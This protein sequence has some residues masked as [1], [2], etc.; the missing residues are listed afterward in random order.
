MATYCT[1][2]DLDEYLSA[3]GVDAFSDHLEL[4]TDPATTVTNCIE[5][6][7][8]EINAVVLK[9]YTLASLVGN[10]ILKDWS[11][12]M[13][14]R[15]LCLRRGNMPPQSLEFEYQEIVDRETGKLRDAE[16]GRI[17]LLPEGSVPSDNLP[18]FSNLTVDRR[19][20]HERVR[21]TRQNSSPFASKA[22]QDTVEQ[23]IADG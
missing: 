22:E 14:C 18:T 3:I 5:R 16:T 1:A 21:V 23:V 4:D 9:R 19:Y 15:Y 7:Y 17:N 12:I 6:A 2:A 13:A 8:R 20:V 10:L 11:T